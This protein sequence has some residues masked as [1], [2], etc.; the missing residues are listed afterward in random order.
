MEKAKLKALLNTLY[1]NAVTDFIESVRKAYGL[2]Q[3]L[4]MDTDA[5][6]DM[7]GDP[8]F[9]SAFSLLD[10]VETR[11]HGHNSV[12]ARYNSGDPYY[13][14]F[15][16]ADAIRSM[17]AGEL[18]VTLSR[19]WF[20][21]DVEATKKWLMEPYARFNWYLSERSEYQKIVEYLLTWINA[22]QDSEFTQAA[23]AILSEIKFAVNHDDMM[24]RLILIRHD[25]TKSESHSH[26]STYT[27]AYID[28][29]N[30]IDNIIKQNNSERLEGGHEISTLKGGDDSDET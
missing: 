15:T 4:E 23:Q 6:Y 7:S 1:G 10:F 11:T 26:P 22:P 20:G 17:T 19:R 13:D 25:V 24:A 3:E 5:I 9:E 30:S 28:I 14:R 2:E 29:L 12:L 8:D 21:S 27:V 18:A 16:N